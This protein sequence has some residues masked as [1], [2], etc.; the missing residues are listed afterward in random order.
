MTQQ[1]IIC[2]PSPSDG[3]VP[4]NSGLGDPLATAFDKTNN[5]FSQL[6]SL[7]QPVPTTLGGQ[8]GDTAGM[9]AYDS[10]YF[11]Y[12]YRNYA[13]GGPIWNKVPNSN[14]ALVG[15]VKANGNIS[16]NGY[17]IGN[18]SLLTGITSTPGPNLFNGNSIVRVYANGNITATVSNVSNVVV[19]TTT[20]IST[21]VISASGNVTAANITTAGTISG[22][23][24]SL[25]G[26]V[27]GTALNVT[28]NVDANNVI[29]TNTLSG[30][31]TGATASLTGNVTGANII[32]GNVYALGVI[33]ATGNVRGG[34]INTGGQVSAAGN[35][36]GNF[37]IGDGGF[38]SNVTISSNVAVS[39]LANGTSVLAINTSGGN[40]TGQIG[41]VANVL[42][43]ATTG[44]IITGGFSVTG[45]ITGANLNSA[46]RVLV[47][48]NVTGGNLT[49]GGNVSVLGNVIGAN[50]TTSGLISATGNITSAA[51]ISGS[52]LIGNGSQLT[53]LPVT[54]GN[55]NVATYLPTYSGNLTANAISAAGNIAGA[56]LIGTIATPSQT[57]ITDVGILNSLSVVGNV[58]S[59][60]ILTGG[61]VSAT[62]SI[63]GGNITGGNIL[64]GG[65]VSATANVVGGN[66]LT[67]G[68]ISASGNITASTAILGNIVNSNGN[69]VGNIGSASTYFNTV[70]AKAT[71]AQYADLAENYL[72]DAEYAP[73]TV[74]SIGGSKEVTMSLNDSDPLVAGVVSTRP[75]YQMNSGLLGEYVASVALVGR[76][77][78]LVQGPITKGAML[79]SAGEGRARAELNPQVGTVIGKALEDFYDNVGTI[80][81]LIG[82]L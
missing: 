30:N 28:G 46:G 42:V 33:S 50:V 61:L 57:T 73:G 37:I 52:Y 74:L 81:I 53:G 70:F 54:Y 51:N 72:A 43:L 44:A 79:V 38:L 17:F 7:Q 60:N 27:V 22:N 71:S 68:I 14:L 56:S 82:K 59:G 5:N 58:S 62:S 47:T 13:N 45:N 6:F 3:G 26:N 12:C 1:V 39:Q 49:S 36:T 77:P 8:V 18:G 24:L 63:T 29:A 40:L 35:V 4:L 11:Y 15:S 75:A 76:V 21:G 16:A 25:S 23:I 10:T 34:N 67:A 2:G 20:G 41:G 32:T 9:T 48:G 78:C 31:L 69:G 64:T 80:E 19:I 66:I 65:L 55:S